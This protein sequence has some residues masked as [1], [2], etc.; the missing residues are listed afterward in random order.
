MERAGAIP[1]IKASEPAVTKKSSSPPDPA[2]QKTMSAAQRIAALAAA[3][4]E[5]GYSS[6]SSS[7]DSA[8]QQ[9]EPDKSGINLAASGTDVLREEERSQPVTRD[10][11]TAGLEVD[12]AAQRL[13]EEP[14]PPPPAPDTG[15]LDMGAVGEMIPNLP[16]D[17]VPISPDTDAIDLSPQGTDFTD[18]APPDAEPPLL[19]LS[20]MELAPAGSDV[21]D[22]KYRKKEQAEAPP[23]DHISLEE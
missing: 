15:H 13:S 18:C 10:I 6:D 11:D 23:T 12:V 22:E 8:E 3:P 17:L 4:D 19:D 14:P 16:S 21:V 9:A 1:V 2:P 5:V 7:T 20:G